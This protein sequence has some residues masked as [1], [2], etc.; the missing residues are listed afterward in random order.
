MVGLIFFVLLIFYEFILLYF[1]HLFL[2]LLFLEY[3][4]IL[5]TEVG[6]FTLFWGR[7]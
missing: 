2:L 5:R 6:D 4:E 3:D 7:E 1:I